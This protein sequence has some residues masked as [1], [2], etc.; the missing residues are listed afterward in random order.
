MRSHKSMVQVTPHPKTPQGEQSVS[1]NCC[2]WAPLLHT[3]AHCCTLLHTAAHCCTLLHT[4]AH[5]CTLLHIAKRPPPCSSEGSAADSESESDLDSEDLTHTPRQSHG[6]APQG[7]HAGKGSRRALGSGGGVEGAS[8]NSSGGGGGDD[9]AGGG[10]G[11]QASQPPVMLGTAAAALGAS[12]HFFGKKVRQDCTCM[13]HQ[14]A[15]DA[16]A[17]GDPGCYPPPQSCHCTIA[18]LS[19]PSPPPLSATVPP[20]PHTRRVTL[21]TVCRAAADCTRTTTVSASTGRR[22][23]YLKVVRP[24]AHRRWIPGLPTPSARVA[25]AWCP[26]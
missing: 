22:T 21:D 10:D 3:A 12:D 11:T 7:R 20:L 15:S 14:P 26:S 1:L 19:S 23:C 2:A 8:G 5:C 18:P 6:R 17:I 25:A 16:A 13:V 4:A 24:P 9:G